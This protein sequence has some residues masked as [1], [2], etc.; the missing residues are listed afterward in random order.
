MGKS[1]KREPGDREKGLTDQELRRYVMLLSIPCIIILLVLAVLAAGKLNSMRESTRAVSESSHS[2]TPANT[3]MPVIEPDT[4]Q[5]FMDFGGSILSQDTVPEINWLMERYFLSISQCDMT[6]FLRLFTSQ[7]T[8]EESRFA[9]EFE[10]QKQYIDGYQNISCYTTPGLGEGDYAAYVYY[11]IRYSGVETPA[12]SLVQIYAV[13]CEDGEYRIY[14]QEPT[15]E[16]EDYL[17]QLSVNED[18]RLLISQVD[19]KTEE[20]MEADPALRQ[21]IEYMKNG[22][23]YMQEN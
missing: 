11:E 21:R 18:V 13:R 16:M 9:E 5:Y 15:P 23:A 22:P 19:Q 10:R 2:A 6:T 7:D 3:A 12:P 8:S 20:A 1:R 17:E 14:D 4:K